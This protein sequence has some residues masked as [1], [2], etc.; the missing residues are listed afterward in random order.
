MSGRSIHIPFASAACV[1]IF[2]LS[3]TGVFA[4]EGRQPDYD[5]PLCRLFRSRGVGINTFASRLRMRRE[6]VE[7]VSP[8]GKR[9]TT[10]QPVVVV[11]N[12]SRASLFYGMYSGNTGDVLNSL[13]Y[14]EEL[15]GG[16]WVPT[17]RGYCGTGIEE[18]ELRAGQ[19]ARFYCPLP[20]TGQEA[21]RRRWMVFYDL[22]HHSKVGQKSVALTLLRGAGESMDVP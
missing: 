17:M 15:R 22:P 5:T 16:K 3:A 8:D 4:Q 20:A 9:A 6:T 13:D 21:P 10:D 19:S 14:T 12:L 7:A 18:Y 1:G 2:A 11:T